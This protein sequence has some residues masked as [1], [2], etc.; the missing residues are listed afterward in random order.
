[1]SSARS[2]SNN[3]CGQLS[4][5]SAGLVSTPAHIAHWGFELYSPNGAALSS[6]SRATLIESTGDEV[7]TF[8]GLPHRY[9]YYAAQKSFE[10]SDGTAISVIGHQGGGAG[11]VSQLLYSADLDLAI[12]VLANADF[13]YRGAC[14]SHG[15]L[16]CIVSELFK[17][18]RD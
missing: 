4:W 17:A 8:G 18:Y 5:A 15:V 1:M 14:R 6:S 7:V 2:S 3:S 11:Y 10:Y 12:S 16:D 9:G 13:R